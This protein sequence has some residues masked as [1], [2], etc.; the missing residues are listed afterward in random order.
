MATQPTVQPKE[1]T[2]AIIGNPN[3]GKSSIF[4]QLTGLNQK[5]GNY[6]GV[7]VDKTLGFLNNSGKQYQLIDLPGYLQYF[8]Q[9]R[10]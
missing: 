1:K 9:I 4:N 3:V 8:S 10:R 6:P 2:I 7:T 5:I